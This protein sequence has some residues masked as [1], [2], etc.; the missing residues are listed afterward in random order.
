MEE[1][2][3]YYG[4]DVSG[5]TVEH[6]SAEA[7][8]AMQI[9]DERF[10]GYKDTWQNAGE[11]L[12]GT[13]FGF[14]KGKDTFVEICI[15]GTDSISFKFEFPLP[16]KLFIF[17]DVYGIELKLRSKDELC[18]LVEM[19]FSSPVMMYKDYLEGYKSAG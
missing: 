11:A 10:A 13:M 18:A 6:G 3:C 5:D 19:F 15:N 1:K 14:S 4:V 2:A 7:A 9:I 16:K 17:R 8:R 12:A